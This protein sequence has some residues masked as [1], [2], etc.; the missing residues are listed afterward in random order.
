MIEPKR[1][2]RT[3]AVAIALG[4]AGFTPGVA[5]ANHGGCYTYGEVVGLDVVRTCTYTA[6]T[7]TQIVHVGTPFTWR[8]WVTRYM[9]NGQPVEIVLAS[10][11]GPNAGPPSL[12][13]PN[14]GE[15]VHVSM[16]YGCISNICGTMGFIGAG[17]EEGHP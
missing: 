15:T 16:D 2:F 7:N 14:V 12:V 1:L 8:V 6:I 11:T 13:N 10:G 17:L 4:A 3:A 5:Q 9:P